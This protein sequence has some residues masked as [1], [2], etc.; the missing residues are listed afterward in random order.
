MFSLKRLAVLLAI[1]GSAWGQPALST[2]N[3]ILYTANGQR[4]T[5]T[6]I[7]NWNSF[8]AGD[9]S[10]IASSMI[11]LAI[12]NGA[13]RVQLVPTTTGS[14]GAQYNVTYNSRGITQFTEVWAVPQSTVPLRVRDVR[15]SSGTIVGPAPVT[16][17]VQI[18]DVVGL[19][20]EL[21]VRPMK[22]VGFAIA[23][24]AIINSAGQIDAASG[25]LGDCV[26]VDG[27]S[28]PCGG[29]GGG[30]LPLFS[31]GETPT[32]VIDG[33]NTT[34]ALIFAPSPAASLDL[35]L[36]GL[37]MKLGT[38]YGI[39]GRII[40]FFLASTPQA[41]DLL[42][43][44]YRYAD[45]NN[46]L[47]TL[48]SPQVVCSSPGGTTSSVALI[49]LG[50][51]TIPAGLIGA[52]DR[53]EVRFQYTHTGSAVGFTGQI[54]FG[55]STIVTRAAVAGETTLAGTLEF[56]VVSGSQSWNAQSW[57]ASLSFLTG[58]GVSGVDTSQAVTV[59]LQGQMASATTDSLALSNFTVVRF[60]AQSNP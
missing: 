8:Q 9:G 38:D 52:G 47:G 53:I 4:F 27:S 48:A 57:G 26:R 42:L 32:G 23:R 21:A 54:K 31:D 17:P 37:R 43:A 6:L 29:A 45:P 7:I 35:F 22:G 56:G 59:S 16:S 13:L 2:I 18:S 24:A 39:S 44:S 28:G 12:V 34:F 55:G 40:T 15:L 1:T 11:T 5:G 25:N 3:D 30:V 14:A 46:P 10:N 33:S 19:T 20:N 49:Q 60:P 51:C 36:N 41:G 58:V 50:S